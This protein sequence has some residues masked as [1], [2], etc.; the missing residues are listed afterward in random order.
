L[1]V[2]RDLKPGNVLV[3][4]GG[5]V[6]LLDF[7]IASLIDDAHSELTSLT[8]LYGR[9]LTLDYASPEQI[10][11]EVT[12]VG[13]DVFSLGVMLFE[14]IT[15]TRPFTPAKPGRAA[16]E[17]AVL[18]QAAP[19]PSSRAKGIPADLDAVVVKA[20]AKSP[21]DRYPTMAAFVA[22]LDRW[23]EH[24]PVL[25]SQRDWRR[26][27]RLWL[28]R[29]RVAAAL[30]A[31]VFASLLAGLALSLWQSVRLQREAEKT[32][33]V[34]A[35]LVSLLEATD[36]SKGS[37]E[38]RS[39][40]GVLDAGRTRVETELAGQPSVQA[41][42]YR[43]LGKGYFAQSEVGIAE[44]LYRRALPLVAAQEG[45]ASLDYAMLLTDIAD[46]VYEFGRYDEACGLYADAERLIPEAAGDTGELTIAVLN[47]LS[48]CKAQAGDVRASVLLRER[49]LAV[50]RSG[51]AAARATEDGLVSDYGLALL[52]AGRVAEAEAQ[53]RLSLAMK[54]RDHQ[55][56]DYAISV[57]LLIET[58]IVQ[59]RYAE[60]QALEAGNE[61]LIGELG[62]DVMTLAFAYRNRARRL[63]ET[64]D[65]AAAL[66]VMQQALSM[67]EAKIGAAAPNVM[68]MQALHAQMLASDGQHAR[69]LE[70]ATRALGQLDAK[71]VLARGRV[72]LSLGA[73]QVLT[74]RETEAIATLRAM[75]AEQTPLLG[76]DHPGIAS[77][78]AWLGLAQARLGAPEAASTLAEAERLLA[79]HATPQL[80]LRQTLRREISTR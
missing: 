55:N 18:H 8:G 79:L 60:A 80:A 25:A 13:V 54:A 34:Q 68:Q 32:A 1:I 76:G 39:L 73:V 70:L 48:A 30:T 19:R 4:A 28:R 36:T 26:D 75:L 72:A 22:D 21:E 78:L 74:G 41:T 67:L 59:G 9:G 3:T 10:A 33:A 57:N 56:L 66:P 17:H 35:F 40:R 45:K 52:R 49:A 77:A 31:M 65:V 2:H 46:A 11:G 47:S 44:D 27:T 23:L 53:F 37:A 20:L 43:V 69:A 42:L 14:L 12:G 38:S 24:R 16:L 58:L 50:A 5:E 6:K 15:D 61:R 71:A 29:N 64:G 51:S 62:S 7:G 63:Y